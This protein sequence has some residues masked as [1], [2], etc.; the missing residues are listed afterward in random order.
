MPTLDATVGG[1][2][3]NSYV[4]VATADTYF[5]ERLRSSAWTTE[6]TDDKERALISA[7]RRL[8]QESF[9]GEKAN[10]A[11]ALKWPRLWSTDDEGTEYAGDAIPVIVQQACM[12]LAL[13]Y[14]VKDDEG[15]DALADTGLE[16]FDAAR[17]GPLSFERDQSFKSGQLPENVRRLLGP[18]LTTAGHS[19]VIERA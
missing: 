18:V 7:A 14:L 1:A 19:V 12:E 4:S 10:T 2:S 3:A 11:Q 17:V 9:D 15:T 5:N 6:D 16:Q 8:D 13:S